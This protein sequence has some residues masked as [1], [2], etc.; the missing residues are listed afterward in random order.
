MNEAHIVIQLNV[1]FLKENHDG[2]AKVSGEY[3]LWLVQKTR[4]VLLV[5]QKITRKTRINRELSSD[6]A[7]IGGT[8]GMKRSNDGMRERIDF[9]R[10]S[11]LCQAFGSWKIAQSRFS[12][13][14][15]P[16]AIYLTTATAP[17]S[18]PAHPF[19]SCRIVY[20]SHRHLS[21]PKVFKVFPVSSNKILRSLHW[22]LRLVFVDT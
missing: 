7:L 13:K 2:I 15:S 9:G 12:K 20:E 14:G 10:P 5:S 3:A 6:Q 11:C 19:L 8:T 18:S 22:I 1:I 16:A 4:F 17:C 21:P